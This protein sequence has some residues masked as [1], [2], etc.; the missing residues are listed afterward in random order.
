[1]TRL[2]AIVLLAGIFLSACHTLSPEG[3]QVIV[4]DHAAGDCN[5]L[6]HVTV[7]I[8]GSDLPSEAIIALR[9]RTADKGGNTLV[10]VTSNTGIAYH[11]PARDD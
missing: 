1:M 9:N 10:L 3:R 2:P 5:H 4:S 8:T 6:G 11:C 7:D